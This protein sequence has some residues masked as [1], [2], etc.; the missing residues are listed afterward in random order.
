MTR[1]HRKTAAAAFQV[2]LFML[3]FAGAASA[4]EY[5]FQMPVPKGISIGSIPKLLQSA[6]SVLEKKIG[7]KLTVQEY[8]YSPTED[9]IEILLKNIDSGKTHFAMIFAIEYTRYLRK[10]KNSKALPMFTVEMFGKTTYSVCM[11]TRTASKI[12]SVKKLKG[13]KWGGGHTTYANYILYKN[14]I[15]TP[16]EKFFKKMIYIPDENINI[17]F[18]ALL[19]KKIDVT[20]MT[21]YQIDMV[22][23]ADKKYQKIKKTK[24]YEYEHNWIIVTSKDV[25]RKDAAGVRKAFLN[26]HKDKDFAQF[27]FLLT[28]IKGKFVPFDEDNLKNSEKIG[29][30]FDKYKW[31]DKEKEFLRK[32][33]K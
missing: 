25:P 28:A 1:L 10:H 4:K 14:K 12:K 9:P 23:N 15:K 2:V 5:F 6:S 24:C 20:F 17:V 29:K 33:M 3:L 32:N 8:S 21:D 13:K 7:A 18:D 19:A 22:R 11:C 26:A 27:R 31:R 30:L 16:P